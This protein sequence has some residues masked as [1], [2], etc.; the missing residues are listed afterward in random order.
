MLR[1]KLMQAAHPK[2]AAP[3]QQA[4]I[5][6][7]SY[8]FTVPAGVTSV[9]VVCVGGGAGGT[10][11]TGPWGQGGGLAYKNSISVTPGESL[12]V[13]V[14]A[15]GAGKASFPGNNGADSRLTRGGTNLVLAAGGNTGTTPVGDVSYSG[16]DNSYAGG[17]AAGYA[18]IGGEGSASTRPADGESAAASSG[19]G[20][21]GA[22][23][24]A[25]YNDIIELY[26]YGASGG[27]GGVGILGIGSTGAGGVYDADIATAGGGEG[28]SGGASGGTGIFDE[29]VESDRMPGGAGGAYGGGG[30]A[31]G[32]L[33]DDNTVKYFST[34]G[35]GAG[36]AVRIIWGAGRSYPS[37]AANV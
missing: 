24:F 27:G 28:G 26:V 8:T 30:G 13:V 20:G 23:N 25:N 3:G 7:G 35:N 1:D 21:G 34:G 33:T 32:L 12:T 36:G 29:T 4:Y 18:G 6:P 17:G 11:A 15:G 31:G 37:N 22:V 9:S 16:G 14:G 5:T 2:V 10:E 19:G